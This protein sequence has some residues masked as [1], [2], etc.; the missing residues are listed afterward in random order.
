MQQVNPT[1]RSD[2]APSRWSYRYQRLM[3]TPGFRL[4][5]RVGLPFVLTLGLGLAYLS[6]A[7][8]RD[9]ITLAIADI[10][11]QIETRPEFMVRL[12]AF[13]G[14]SPW[15]EAEL[16]EVFPYDFPVSSFDLELE[17]VRRLIV[18][19]SAVADADVRVRQGGVLMAR[20]TER[21]PVALWRTRAGLRLIDIEGAEIASVQ[22]RGDRAGLPVVAGKGADRAIPEALEI[23]AAAAPL[24]DRVLGLVRV[25][26]RRW[27]LV[28]D[29]DQRILL[30][31]QDP[32]R[33]LERVIV[34]GDAQDMLERDLVAV[35]MR[36]AARPTIRMNRRAVEEWWRVMK[37]STGAEQ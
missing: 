10:R 16:R 12:L 29:R 5:L 24:A 6:D 14:V 22:Q 15:V 25:G 3:L 18:A 35:D 13:E 8:R 19:H 11:Q 34:L 2:P 4:L 9:R 36:L 21:R 7:A 33:A 30:P 23:M 37:I 28:L 26:E 31:V 32:V 27:D 20:V 17:D 1:P